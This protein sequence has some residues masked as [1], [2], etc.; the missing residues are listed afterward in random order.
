MSGQRS[1][2]ST[3]ETMGPL[4]GT[5]TDRSS[6][7][8]E[9]RRG[10][11]IGGLSPTRERGRPHKPTEKAGGTGCVD[12]ANPTQPLAAEPSGEDRATSIRGRTCPSAGP[13]VELW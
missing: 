12:D 7:L 1:K 6:A 3:F 10:I 11:V 9:V 8:R 5:D 13:I 4:R 2:G